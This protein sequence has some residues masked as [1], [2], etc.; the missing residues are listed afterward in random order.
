M[1]IEVQNNLKGYMDYFINQ[2]AL[3]E[4]TIYRVIIDGEIEK[5][6]GLFTGTPPKRFANDNDLEF[7]MHRWY[8]HPM[9]GWGTKT[10]NRMS[11]IGKDIE[12]WKLL[13]H[14]PIKTFEEWRL[15]NYQ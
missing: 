8:Q 13:K 5:I 9:K 15:K 4:W 11:M 12:V 6:G 7:T 3:R 14:E 2:L 1:E 10:D